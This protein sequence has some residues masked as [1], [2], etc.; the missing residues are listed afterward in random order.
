MSVRTKIG[1]GFNNYIRE[2]ELGWDD[3]AFSVFTTNSEDVEGRPLF[4]RFAKADSMKVVPL[5]LS[6][7][8]ISLSDHID[9]DESQ[10]SYSTKSSTFSDS[11]FVSNDFVSCDDSD[12]S[13]EVN[14]NDFASSDSSV[15]SSEPKLNDSTSC[16]SISS[17]SISENKAEI[18]SNVGH[19][20]KNPLFR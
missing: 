8:Y 5:P 11:K 7:D 10:M 15:Q 17:V 14:I 13:L 19:L 6:G 12:K 1:L 2:N 16:E 18:E 3:S 20:S 4:N 9:L